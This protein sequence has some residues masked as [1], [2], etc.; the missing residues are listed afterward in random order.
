MTCIINNCN[1]KKIYGK[2][3]IIHIN[4]DITSDNYK[5]FFREC[6][7]HGRHRNEIQST[8]N[9]IFQ[10]K[11]DF[12][13]T[14]FEK[15]YK[16]VNTY[17]LKNKV[18]R[19]NTLLFKYDV[20]T[21]LCKF[22]NIPINKTYLCGKGPLKFIKDHNLSN[23]IKCDENGLQYIDTDELIKIINVNTIN[24]T[25]GNLDMFI[26]DQLE[27]LICYLSKIK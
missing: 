23:K 14:S 26:G 13:D 15:V 8:L 1:K 21:Q 25:I 3:C 27:T 12:L 9:Y 19:T 4:G 17:I 22:F 18:P 20:T 10:H 2:Y 7:F 11:D 16:K 24:D 5:D 6:L